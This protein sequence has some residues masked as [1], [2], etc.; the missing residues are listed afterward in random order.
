[1]RKAS[2]NA[3]HRK[4]KEFLQDNKT[5]DHILIGGSNKVLISAPHGVPQV[6]LG[7]VKY[8]E[9]GSLTTSLWLKEMTD[10]FLI[11]KTRNN[12]D[13]ANWD[14]NSAYKR[15]I[16]SVVE[17]YGIKYVIDIHGLAAK[18]TCDIN[19]GTHLGQNT[20]KNPKLLDNLMSRLEKDFIISIDQPFMANKNTV[21][22]YTKQKFDNIW[23]LQIEINC[24][25][26]NKKENFDRFQKLLNVLK[27][28]I[29][30]LE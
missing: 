24:A 18:S 28:W 2:F 29:S 1:M 8:P 10:S 22:T 7:K 19:F 26:S 21:A 20:S 16:C 25:I 15:A 3:L 6:R 13:D 14:E 9:L 23:T 30:T 11:A 4:R 17:K 12:C 5:R 27:D